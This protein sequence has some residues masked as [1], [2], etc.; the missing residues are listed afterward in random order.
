MSFRALLSVLCAAL[1]SLAQAS[2]PQPTRT[3]S[4]TWGE[5]APFAR[6]G[7]L[8]VDGDTVFVAGRTGFDL[9]ALSLRSG[10]PRWLG[11]VAHGDAATVAAADGHVY[12][13]GSVEV[14]GQGAD[15]YVGAWDAAEG[16]LLWEDR[17]DH[18][19]LGDGVRDLAVAGGRIIAVGTVSTYLRFGAEYRVRAY[20]AATG[21]PLWDDLKATGGD[22]RATHVVAREDGAW[23]LGTIAPRTIPDLFLRAYDPATGA[24]RWSRRIDIAD[25]LPTGLALLGDR[26]ALSAE[27]GGEWLV[28]GRRAVD[29]RR[30]WQH[31]D[32][33]ALQPIGVVAGRGLFVVAGTLRTPVGFEMLTRAYDAATGAVIWQDRAIGPGADLHAT[34][35][36]RHRDTILVAGTSYEP[37]PY[38]ASIRVRALDLETG[39]LRWE[40]GYDVPGADEEATAVATLRHRLV[41]G[42]LSRSFEGP[43]SALLLGYRTPR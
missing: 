1:L 5:S 37:P 26:L 14:P 40:F 2:V 8:A 18:R 27:S 10:E 13:G 17:F 38:G 3:W 21:R 30:L 9:R 7:D 33:D 32:R 23:V 4:S 20:D 41:V 6:V 39:T 12:A 34:A 36:A 24:V 25:E 22:D 35:A 29:G 11:N 19:Q 43:A 28:Q 15:W 42:G 31:R 16:Q